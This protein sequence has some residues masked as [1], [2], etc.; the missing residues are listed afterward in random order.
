MVVYFDEALLIHYALDRSNGHSFARGVL[1]QDYKDFLEYTDLDLALSRTPLPEIR[2]GT[3]VVLSEYSFVKEASG[4]TKF[5]PI[6]REAYLR[7]LATDVELFADPQE[8]EAAKM[9]LAQHGLQPDNNG[10]RSFPRKVIDKIR[11]ETRGP[12]TKRFWLLL[13][14]TLKIEPP[15]DQRFGFDTLD[16]AF[17]YAGRYPRKKSHDLSVYPFHGFPL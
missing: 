1:T 13:A 12:S 9:L 11:W 6:D 16:E 4:S 2:T 10:G 5:P 17:A 3:N 14:R 15:G 8:K 7:G